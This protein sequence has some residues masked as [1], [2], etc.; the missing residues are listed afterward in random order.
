MDLKR[1]GIVVGF[2]FA[3]FFGGLFCCGFVLFFGVFFKCLFL[4]I[5]WSQGEEIRGF[6]SQFYHISSV[7][8]LSFKNCVYSA[9]YCFE[10]RSESLL[11]NLCPG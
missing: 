11:Q 6:G 5:L 10:E 3:G 1:G 7:V 8:A 2:L 4:V 9:V